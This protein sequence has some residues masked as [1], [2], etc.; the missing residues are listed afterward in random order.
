MEIDYCC[1]KGNFNFLHQRP[2]KVSICSPQ[3]R[4]R[5]SEHVCLKLPSAVAKQKSY[6]FASTVTGTLCPSDALQQTVVATKSQKTKVTNKYNCDLLI[7]LNRNALNASLQERASMGER[8][9]CRGP[10]GLAI[11]LYSFPQ[12]P[13][14]FPSTPRVEY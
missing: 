8:Q 9:E 10:V 5:S 11:L 12:L 2:R 1:C 6:T 4:P 7:M 13:L 14:P 3:T